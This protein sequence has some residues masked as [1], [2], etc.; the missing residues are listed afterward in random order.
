MV[1]QNI[2]KHIHSE[3]TSTHKTNTNLARQ[4]PNKREGGGQESLHQLRNIGMLWLLGEQEGAF[5]NY[6]CI[7]ISTTYQT[8]LTPK[9]S[10]VIQAGL[11]GERKKKSFKC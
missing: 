9:T 5:F 10:W 3:Y 8:G 7:G 4:N 11:D 1:F 2:F 6:V